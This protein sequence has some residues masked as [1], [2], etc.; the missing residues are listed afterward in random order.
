MPGRYSVLLVA[1]LIGGA[2]SGVQ[3]PA[4]IVEEIRQLEQCR[5]SGFKKPIQNRHPP[6]K[7]LWHKHYQQ[8]GLASF[9]RNVVQGLNRFGIPFFQE[10]IR[11]AEAAGEERYLEPEDVPALVDEIVRGNRQ[12]L[13]ERRLP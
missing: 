7:G 10:K 8:N 5:F 2:L 6:L 4:T 9:A 1:N 3:N 12:R 13:A 11:E